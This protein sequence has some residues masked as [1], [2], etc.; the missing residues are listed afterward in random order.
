MRDDTPRARPAEESTPEGLRA[1][2]SRQETGG[3]AGAAAG[4][5][6]ERT[7]GGVLTLVCFKCGNEYHFDEETPPDDL[8]CD[9]C[10]GTVFRSFFSPDPADEVARDFADSTER[11]LDTDQPSTDTMPGDV[12]DLNPD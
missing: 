9:K 6:P 7:A 2:Q 12:A 10:G 1:A 5:G 11:D 4:A 3:E 8:S